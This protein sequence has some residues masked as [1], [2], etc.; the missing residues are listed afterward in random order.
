MNNQTTTQAQAT[1]DDDCCPDGCDMRVVDNSFGHQLGT[2]RI[3][4][5]LQCNNCP[6]KEPMP[7]REF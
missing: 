5:F 1:E 4:P 2:E 7:E 3:P 6:R